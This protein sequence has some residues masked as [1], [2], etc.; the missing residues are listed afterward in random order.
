LHNFKLTVSILILV[1]FFIIL[2]LFLQADY[3]KRRHKRKII[4]GDKIIVKLNSF[5]G[6]YKNQQI[7][8]YLRKI[9]PYVFEELILSAFALKGFK[10]IR[11]KSYS[12]DGGL[13]GMILN[14]DDV[15]L[16]QAKRYT[17]LIK[18]S[19]IKDFQVLISQK[20]AIGGY[21][22]HTG[23]TYGQ[24]LTAFK[25]STIEIISGQKLIDLIIN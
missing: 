18:T 19:H 11:N 8:S 22:I 21:F 17:N 6:E 1:I 7:L 9:D 23:R 13:D 5:S 10:I 25:N 16:I 20:N 12:D 24:C 3:K 15:F 2:K 14:N 4:S